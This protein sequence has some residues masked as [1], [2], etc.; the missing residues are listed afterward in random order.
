MYKK[1]VCFSMVIY[2]G[3]LRKKNTKVNKQKFQNFGLDQL[4]YTT[5]S[6]QMPENKKKQI[7]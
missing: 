3:R 1:N 5:T 7:S 2:H 6:P 4:Q